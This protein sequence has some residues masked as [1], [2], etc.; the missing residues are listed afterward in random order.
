M[1]IVGSYASNLKFVLG[2]VIVGR[3]DPVLQQNYNLIVGHLRKTFGQEFLPLYT[4][5]LAVKRALHDIGID[6]D[7]LEKEVQTSL[8]F[9]MKHAVAR[10]FLPKHI[11]FEKIINFLSR[12]SEKIVN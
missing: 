10:D 2:G 1:T 4:N 7:Y 9:E 8:N 3:S 5:D 6:A 11:F 12:H